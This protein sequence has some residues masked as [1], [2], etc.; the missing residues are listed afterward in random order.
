MTITEP[1]RLIGLIYISP[2]LTFTIF[3]P[4][5]TFL[6]NSQI[7][8]FIIEIL[9][10]WHS[11][12]GGSHVSKDSLATANAIIF[13]VKVSIERTEVCLHRIKNHEN[14]P[15]SHFGLYLRK[16]DH[17]ILCSHCMMR[18][19]SAMISYFSLQQLPYLN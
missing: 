3:R 7:S 8:H 13:S 10:S 9:G 18:K 15:S 11:I 1:Y 19:W 4:D 2:V 17:A 16:P 14:E 12:F 5:T 6:S